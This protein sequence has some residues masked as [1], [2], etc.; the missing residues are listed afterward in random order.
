MGFCGLQGLV[1]IKSYCNCCDCDLELQK[2]AWLANTTANYALSAAWD[3]LINCADYPSWL[4]RLAPRILRHPTLLWM[5]HS[6]RHFPNRDCWV[7]NDEP[8]L[9]LCAPL[10]RTWVPADDQQKEKRH[11]WP[12]TCNTHLVWAQAQ[13][14]VTHHHDIKLKL[15]TKGLKP[16]LLSMAPALPGLTRLQAETL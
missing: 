5:T 9:L 15:I 14:E 4:S 10:E 6:W 7:M 1:F 12:N 8:S 16:L 11:T 3:N 13:C 2:Q